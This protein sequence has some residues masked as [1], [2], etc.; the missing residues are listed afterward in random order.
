LWILPAVDATIE[1]NDNTASVNL[2]AAQMVV[3]HGSSVTLHYLLLGGI[4][5]ISSDFDNI[6]TDSTD[7]FTVVVIDVFTYVGD[8]ELA[9]A[10]IDVNANSAVMNVDGKLLLDGYFR[11]NADSCY[12]DD[13]DSAFTLNVVGTLQSSAFTAYEGYVIVNVTGKYVSTATED[14]LIMNVTGTGAVSEKSSGELSVTKLTVGTASTN[15]KESIN[16]ASVK[17]S[18]DVVYGIVYGTPATGAISIDADSTIFYLTDDEVIYATLYS[19]NDAYMKYLVP[20]VVGYTFNNWFTEDGVLVLKS[21]IIVTPIGDIDALYGQ[22]SVDTYEVTFSYTQNGSWII[23]GNS[24]QGT[25]VVAYSENGYTVTFIA[26]NGYE[27]KDVKILVNGSAMPANYMPA[28]DDVLTIS[29]SVVEKSAGPAGLS[30][31]DILLIV[32]VII[33][34]I[35]AVVVILKLMRS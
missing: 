4:L 25:Q 9:G 7:V 33:I 28:N 16:D 21:E 5:T 19:N 6:S 13:Y 10:S 17:I 27:L 29:G 18:G 32:M 8:Y 3:N 24:V 30:V 35:I 2:D 1:Y 12:S 23:N 26:D 11:V 14:I 20:K 34:A 31:T 22:F 15:F